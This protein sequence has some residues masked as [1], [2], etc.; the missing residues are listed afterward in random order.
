MLDLLS[1]DSAWIFVRSLIMGGQ[2][3]LQQRG[4]SQRRRADVCCV[5]EV[6]TGR[7][8]SYC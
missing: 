2:L 7:L 3:L 4:T 5:T 8:L 1:T 6:I